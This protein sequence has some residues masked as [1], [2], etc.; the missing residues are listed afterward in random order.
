MCVY[1]MVPDFAQRWFPH[2]GI[3]PWAPSPI[4]PYPYTYPSFPT[5]VT[6]TRDMLTEFEELVKRVKE[7]E[8]KANVNVGEPPCFNDPRKLDFIEQIREILDRADGADGELPYSVVTLPEWNLESGQVAIY[9][10]DAPYS[11]VEITTGP[12]AGRIF[13]LT[14]DV[15]LRVPDEMLGGFTCKVTKSFTPIEG[16]PWAKR[17]T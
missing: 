10:V 7:L 15:Y 11:K 6:W 14:R 9:K 16:S 13:W 5:T 2:P 17:G 4:D 12:G 1:C 8:E 3:Q